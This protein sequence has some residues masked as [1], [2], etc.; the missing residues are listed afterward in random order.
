[1]ETETPL[2]HPEIAVGVLDLYSQDTLKKCIDSIPP[3]Y[4][5]GVASN[6]TNDQ[7]VEDVQHFGFY[8]KFNTHV[9]IATMRNILLTNFRNEGF[10]YYFLIGSNHIVTDPDIFVKTIQKANT[11]GTWFMT[12]PVPKTISIEDE[13]TKLE[14]KLSDHLNSDVLFTFSGIIKSN[15]YFHEQFYNGKDLDVIDYTYRLRDKGIYLSKYYHPTISEGFQITETDINKIGFADIPVKDEKLTHSYGYFHH[16]HKEIP[17]SE[18]LKSV[19]TDKV[20]QSLE[21]LQK[22]YANKI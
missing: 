1:M 9:P 3:Q 13:T 16:V 7:S 11:F 18:N 22:N 10:K 21:I 14:L 17:L 6:N 12:G 15:G 19:E 4:F 5:V 2:Y 20:L 8:Q